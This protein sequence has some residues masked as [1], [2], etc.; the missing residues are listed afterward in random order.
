MLGYVLNVTRLNAQS[1]YCLNTGKDPRTGIDSFSFGKD[2]VMSLLK[3]NMVARLPTMKNRAIRT[4]IEMFI[5]PL[6]KRGWGGGA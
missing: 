2:L 4:K 1:F 3:P 5:K 6:E